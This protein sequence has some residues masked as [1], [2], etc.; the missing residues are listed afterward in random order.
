MATNP[1]FSS[2][3]DQR[4]DNE[5]LLVEDLIVEAI[6]LTGQNVYYIPRE[7]FDEGDMIY[8]EYSKSKFNK[9]YLIEAYISPADN[10]EGQH[11]FFSKFGLEIRDTSN[12]LLSRRS[13]SRFIPSSMRSRPQEGDL[14][15][16]PTFRR[17]F[18]IKFV[19]EEKLHFTLGK[20]NPYVY[21]LRCE[22]FR[23]SQ[24]PIDTG[25]QEV[26]DVSAENSYTIKLVLD[27]TGTGTMTPED[28]V[29]QSTDGTYANVTSQGTIKEWFS[30]NGTLFVHTI[31]GNFVVNSNVYSVTTN[32]SYRLISKDE[33][34]DYVTYDLFDNLGF[35]TETE[36]VVDLTE[37]NPFGEI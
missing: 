13:F 9:A 5:N 12:F 37:T 20:R 36:L 18:E 11:D 2:P 33:K 24:E 23:Y 25:V 31:N 29:Y 21:E 30:A 10:F 35:D 22:L 28:I 14:V 16:A 32:A 15:Y 34:G 6:Q 26:D 8:G 19:E 27:T 1:Y 3:I 4:I 7:S 17:M